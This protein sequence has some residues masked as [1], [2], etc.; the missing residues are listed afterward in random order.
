MPPHHQL[1]V[2][3]IP[4]M[5]AGCNFNAPN[6]LFVW[7]VIISVS[8]RGD[9]HTW[10]YAPAVQ[11]HSE[12]CVCGEWLGAPGEPKVRP[13]RGQA[14]TAAVARPSRNISNKSG[15]IAEWNKISVSTFQILLLLGNPKF[16]TFVTH[17][18]WAKDKKKKKGVCA[19]YYLFFRS[20]CFFTQQQQ[21][22]P[23]THLDQ[24][25]S[26]LPLPHSHP[27]RGFPIHS[28]LRPFGN[29]SGW[30]SKP[31]IQ[32]GSREKV[33]KTFQSSG[34]KWWKTRRGGHEKDTLE[35]GLTPP[36]VLIAAV[37]N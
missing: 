10:K 14:E 31:G 29:F 17:V 21:N 2:G 33:R 3:S 4:D 13:L 28:Q 35:V 22:H 25:T 18:F 11:R 36:L 16:N 19:G 6:L 24:A 1:A 12:V 20:V 27:S 30:G 9:V 32:T 15:V 37:S 7:F 8:S 34:T 5:P 26:P 23:S